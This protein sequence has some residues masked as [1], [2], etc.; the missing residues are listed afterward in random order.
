MCIRDSDYSAHVTWQDDET[1]SLAASADALGKFAQ[2]LGVP[3]EALWNK[4]PGVTATDVEE[5][6]VLKEQEVSTDPSIALAN[7]LTQTSQPPTA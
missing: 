6:R 1:T 2:M 3:V 7:A 4:I 5:W